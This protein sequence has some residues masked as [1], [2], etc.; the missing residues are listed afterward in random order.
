M[1]YGDSYLD[2]E[3]GAV[4]AHFAPRPEPALMTVFRNAGRWDTSNVAFRDGQVVRYNKRQPDP[5][6]AYIDYGANLFRAEALER[7][8]PD[9]PYDLGD[10][11]HALAAE[12]LLAGHEVTQRFYEVGS[13]DGIR[14]PSSIFRPAP[15]SVARMLGS[16]DA[17]Q[18]VSLGSVPWLAASKMAQHLVHRLAERGHVDV[19]PGV[20]AVRA[21][22]QD[23]IAAGRL[24]GVRRRA[25]DLRSRTRPPRRSPS[26]PPRRRSCRYPACGSGR[27]SCHRAGRRRRRPGGR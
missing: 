7:I 2:I 12:G 5:E 13:F 19:A 25:T 9:E 10:L 8:P 15:E 14:R 26:A 6:M 18:R 3:Y 16:D 20:D 23:R 24:P 17:A 22:D 21:L 27:P 1:L 11:S 4:L